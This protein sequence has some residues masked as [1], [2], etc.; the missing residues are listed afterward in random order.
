MGID[1]L[2][3]QSGNMPVEREKSANAAQMKIL[4][5]PVVGVEKTA[6]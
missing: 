1:C 2:Q 6:L 5:N 3:K 4:T